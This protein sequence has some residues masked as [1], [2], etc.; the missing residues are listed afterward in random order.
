MK[1][2]K[3]FVIASAIIGGMMMSCSDDGYWDKSGG[4]GLGISS[5]G[6]TFAFNSDKTTFT[7]YPADN[8]K[9]TDLSVTLTRSNSKGAVTVPVEAL[10]EHP[11]LLSGPESVTFADGS[12]TAEYVIHVSDDIEIG[13]S[14]YASLVIPDSVMG[15][16]PVEMP[17]ELTETSTPED[18]V[19]Y[20][21]QLAE[22]QLY[23]KRMATY[24][25]STMVVVSKDYNWT[26]L[27]TAEFSDNWVFE[28]SP[29]NAEL[30]RAEEDPDLFRLVK[31][32]DPGLD[33][34]D[35]KPDYYQDGP[36]EYVQFELLH[37]GDNLFGITITEDNLVYFPEFRTGYY[38][39]SYSAEI[40]CEH[41]SEFGSLR[42]EDKWLQNK[43]VEYQEN[44]LPAI[45]Q[46]APY[47]YMYGYGGWNYTQAS[48]VIT[49]VFPGVVIEDFSASVAYAGLFTDPDDNQFVL[50]NVTL[51]DNVDH[52]W[53][54]VVEGKD[55]IDGA[56][57]AFASGSLLPA[58]SEEE[59]P[60]YVEVT[61]GGQIQ[62]PMIP[63][64]ASGKY[65]IAI[66]TFDA[67]GN[68]IDDYQDYDYTTFSY[69]GSGEAP[70][71]WT[72]AYVGD[73]VYTLEFTEDDGSPYTDEGLVLY[74]SDKDSSRYKIEHWGYDVDFIFTMDDEGTLTVEEQET[75]ATYGSY[76]PIYVSTFD[77]YFSDY[78]PETD[79]SY[80]DTGVFHFNLVYHVSA[81]TMKGWYGEE[82]YTLTG[83]AGAKS[84][85]TAPWQQKTV[86]DLGTDFTKKNKKKVK[87]QKKVEFSSAEANGRK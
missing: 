77:E 28:Y 8:I 71:T 6:S 23:V 27:G 58:D 48:G 21:K 14:S 34:E 32:Y 59:G 64:A 31:P 51:G 81:G 85:I 36:S 40:W 52:A 63:D 9:D 35:F 53:V 20:N 73:F 83:R 22:Y 65:T 68:V 26:T 39:P 57:E 15:I 46:L 37:P 3:L 2:Y 1:R 54:T 29:Y 5:D 45:V 74:Q 87:I 24:Q 61:E 70:E 33:D 62:I 72:A 42:S 11:D 16:T 79:R 76:G 30:Q 13:S 56:Y 50:A 67:D 17:E 7:Y 4:K 66:F 69:T 10:F 86:R 38:N 25:L 60:K 44:G 78:D 18:T 55:N 41:P 49:I 12:K 19:A 82:T 75:G 84:R 43:V 80:Y 47:Y